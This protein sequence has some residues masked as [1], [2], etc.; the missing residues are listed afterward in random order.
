VL[1]HTAE[2]ALRTVLFIAE[3]AGDEPVRVHEIATALGIPRNYLSKTLHRLA[4][5]GILTSSRG[6]GGG[7]R[8]T[9]APERLRLLAVVELFDDIGAGR[10][11]LLGR[12]VCSDRTACRAHAR[13][14]A[15]GEAVAGF[16]RDTTV[17]DLLEGGR[18]MSTVY[19]ETRSWSGS[20]GRS[21]NRASPG[22]R[23]A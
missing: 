22:S 18:R 20:S 21:S 16:F 19:E 10:R 15:T 9:V 2:Y 12:P 8:L 1:S 13:W 14:K 4:R 6:K 5:S 7:F 11:C 17:A 23:R 3:H